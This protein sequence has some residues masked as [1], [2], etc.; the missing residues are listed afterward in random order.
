MN[1]L[2]SNARIKKD[3]TFDSKFFLQSKQQEYF[4]DHPARRRSQKNAHLLESAH[5]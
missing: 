3:K 2:L 1:K 4:V 5:N